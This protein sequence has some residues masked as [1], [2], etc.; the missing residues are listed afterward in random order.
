M[1]KVS[2]LTGPE[3]RYGFGL[4]GVRHFIA[5]PEDLESTIHRIVVMADVGLLVIDEHLAWGLTDERMRDIE[6]MLHGI[7]VVLP[8]PVKAP[9]EVEDYAARLIRRAIGY[10]VR[11]RT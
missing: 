7:V 10:H 1:K 5:I 11:I 6:R 8:A 3:T 2:F 4:A 9:P